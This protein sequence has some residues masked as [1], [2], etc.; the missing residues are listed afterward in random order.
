MNIA[1]FGASGATGFPLTQRCLAAGHS[2]TALLRRP[3]AFSLRGAVRV[4]QGSAFD[5]EPVSRTIEGAD[6]VLSTLGASS[7]GKEEVLERGVPQIIAA[8]E[9]QRVR[10]IVVLGAAGA[11]PHGWDD[12]SPWRRWIAEHIIV[13]MILKN[14]MASQRVQYQALSATDLDW[15]M[16]MPPMLTK[17][18]GHGAWRIGA[19]ALPHNA[20]RIARED[21]AQFMLQQ[22]GDPQW[23]KKAVYIA[24]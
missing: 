20:N 3:E 18:R 22:I 15:T 13:D 10:R 11:I 4:V 5:A 7:L 24:W 17:G 8:M 1:I 14:P 19:N 23:I 9:Q 16:V 21:V 12:Q 6:A 2:V